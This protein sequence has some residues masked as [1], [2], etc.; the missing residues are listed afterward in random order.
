MKYVYIYIY[1]HIYI[2]LHII[3]IYLSIDICRY[4]LCMGYIG[5]VHGMYVGCQCFFYWST[6]GI[7]PAARHLPQ[8]P[9][10]SGASLP[11]A[12]DVGATAIE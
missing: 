11:D 12:A 1:I 9:L 10:R 8:V 3:H 6:M 7:S 4:V 2:Y 5:A